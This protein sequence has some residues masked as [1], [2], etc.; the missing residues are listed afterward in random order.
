MKAKLKI[1]CLVLT[2]MILLPV[3]ATGVIYDEGLFAGKELSVETD[4]NVVAEHL[5]SD[6]EKDAEDFF[7]DSDIKISLDRT[8]YLKR[9]VIPFAACVTLC[10]AV[11]LVS[12]FFEKQKK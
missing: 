6:D 4:E 11:F 9:F 2:I 8:G 7:E 1:F 5:K 10:T 12:A 3:G